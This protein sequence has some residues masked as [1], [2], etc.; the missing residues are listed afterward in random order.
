M[1]DDKRHTAGVELRLGHWLNSK[2]DN[3]SKDTDKRC[4]LPY[5]VVDLLRELSTS[6]TIPYTGVA[7]KII[8]PL[9]P[10]CPNHNLRVAC[11]S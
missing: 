8:A 2:K 1:T 5:S 11:V 4:T 10:K 6:P 9:K 3:H 7:T